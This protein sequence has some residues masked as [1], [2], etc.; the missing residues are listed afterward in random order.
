LCFGFPAK[1]EG[2]QPHSPP[3]SSMMTPGF[4]GM[5]QLGPQIPGLHHTALLP[6]PLPESAVSGHGR[7]SLTAPPPKSKSGK[8]RHEHIESMAKHVSRFRCIRESGSKCLEWWFGKRLANPPFPPFHRHACYGVHP[9]DPPDWLAAADTAIFRCCDD[10]L[11]VRSKA[12]QSILD[13]LPTR[14]SS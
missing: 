5:H 1:C 7:R 13:P 8:S 6:A 2:M 4:P 12:P 3:P 9:H 14:E 10:V 11:Q